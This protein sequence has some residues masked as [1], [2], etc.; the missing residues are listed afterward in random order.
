MT[1]SDKQAL[2]VG[3][4]TLSKQ[5][6]VRAR[7]RRHRTPDSVNCLLLMSWA[8]SKYRSETHQ[9]CYFQSYPHPSLTPI[10]LRCLQ[11]QH[12]QYIMETI[13]CLSEE[14]WKTK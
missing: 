1:V 9:S 6:L 5:P 10:E 14:V 11:Y 12:L 13:F 3:D 7:G 2:S 8:D 4:I